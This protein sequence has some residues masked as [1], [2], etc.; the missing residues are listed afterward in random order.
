MSLSISALESKTGP[1]LL[2][3]YNGAAA[4]LGEKAVN[5][6]ADK[7][8]AVRRT[9]D[10]LK[11]AEEKTNK[12]AASRAEVTFPKAGTFEAQPLPEA[13]TA[14][15][16]GATTDTPA[17][18]ATAAK[19]I[20]PR[21]A[22]HALSDTPPAKMKALRAPKVASAPSVSNWIRYVSVSDPKYTIRI[23]PKSI[24]RAGAPTD[25]FGK[26]MIPAAN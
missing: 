4:S 18:A 3:L 12:K 17:T 16:A 6:F 1:E 23:S 25:P 8:A 11:R 5:R 10:I 21:P 20:D 19:A 2:D 14:V 26:K 7:S 22:L 24:E 13:P 9:A 15:A